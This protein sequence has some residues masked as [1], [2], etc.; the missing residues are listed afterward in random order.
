MPVVNGD[1]GGKAEAR[2][3]IDAVLRQVQRATPVVVGGLTMTPLLNPSAR[4]A[5]YLTLE[6]AMA[7]GSLTVQE[8]SQGGHVPELLVIN[9]ASQPVFIVDGEHLLGAKQ[10]RVVNL[11]VMVPPD[12]KMVISVTCVEQGRWARRTDHFETSASVLFSSGRASKMSQVSSSM[13]QG[14]DPRADQ[15]AVWRSV[16]GLAKR[17]RV[18]SQ[19]GSMEDIFQEHR[20]STD[21][22][23]AQFPPVPHQVG[24]LL[25]AQGRLCGIELFDAPSTWT[26]LMPRVVQSWAIEASDGPLENKPAVDLLEK[27]YG[28]VWDVSPSRG[29]GSDARLDAGPMTAAGLVVDG[30][31][32]HLAGFEN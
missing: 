32:V 29:Q 13:K 21:R 28:V 27:L 12:S 9:S 8:V 6:E 10:N 23:V 11:S 25:S 15:H 19:T 17:R 24:A 20:A 2:Q 4:V 22:V 1:V 18:H 7:Q 26:K 16:D 3:A 5:P 31:V 14:Q 30:E